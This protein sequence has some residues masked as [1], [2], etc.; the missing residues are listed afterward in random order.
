MSLW[1]YISKKVKRWGQVKAKSSFD[2]LT[3]LGPNK[4][5]LYK[6]SKDFDM[7]RN[8]LLP[9]LQC[10]VLFFLGSLCQFFVPFTKYCFFIPMLM[11]QGANFSHMPIAKKV[12]EESG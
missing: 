7:L 11:N 8:S 4:K 10:H 5:K 12:L 3:L 2:L 6:K 9:L 1:Q